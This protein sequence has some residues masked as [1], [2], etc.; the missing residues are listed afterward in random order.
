M[1]AQRS[2]RVGIIG[3]GKIGKIRH[4][5]VRRNPALMLMGICDFEQI[6]P[7]DGFGVYQ[8][9]K[10]LLD[11]KPDLVF[12]CTFNRFIPEIAIEA[13]KRGIHVFS[14]KPA[15]RTLAD[16]EAIR[17]VSFNNR[18]VKVKYGF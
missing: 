16:V 6:L 1:I 17:E 7:Q 13:I 8:D 2:L 15:G 10:I 11:A 14:E 4:E 5:C 18:K 3:Y 9:Y 12:I